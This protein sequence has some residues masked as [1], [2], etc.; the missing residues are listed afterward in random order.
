MTTISDDLLREAWEAWWAQD[1]SGD[2]DAHMRAV[3]TAVCA[4]EAD[5]LA[6]VTAERDALETTC[7]HLGSALTRLS[8][9]MQAAVIAEKQGRRGMDLIEDDIADALMYPGEPGSESEWDGS[10]T[11]EAYMARAL[12][13]AP[14]AAFPDQPTEGQQ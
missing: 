14:L 13:P 5:R 9:V 1:G 7:R 12:I 11:P 10:E 4:H 8:V 2:D 3:I 6:A